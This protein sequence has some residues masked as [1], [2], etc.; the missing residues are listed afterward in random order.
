[1]TDTPTTNRP[2]FWTWA[3]LAVVLTAAAV[4]SFA[5]LRDLA[6]SCGVA[7]SLA[8]LL[9]VTVDA[10]S[11]VSTRAWLS[12]RADP[13]SERFARGMTWVQLS[14]TV[15][16]NAAHQGMVAYG[17]TPPWWMAVVVGAI[18]AG[19]VGACVHLAVLLGRTQDSTGAV[20]AS[21]AAPVA[22]A[23]HN[24][25]VS[26]EPTPSASSPER[27][28]VEESMKQ[29]AAPRRSTGIAKTAAQ[30]QRDSRAR[31]REKAEQEPHRLSAV[32]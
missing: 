10:G 12:K 5:N 19:T 22:P 29:P 17:I 24:S 13:E 27:P 31:K 32:R 4:L 9:P 8:F 2:G 20:V 23:T 3:G 15:I 28:T 14:L 25:D 1:M 11:A 7:A 6:A 18:P 16:L 26:V 30:R 21:P